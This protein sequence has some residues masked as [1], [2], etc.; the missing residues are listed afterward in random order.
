[1][2]IVET[3]VGKILTMVPQELFCDEHQDLQQVRLSDEFL[4][5]LE[6]MEPRPEALC[7]GR[8]LPRHISSNDESR[9]HCLVLETDRWLFLA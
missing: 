6:R 8:G 2:S 9:L 5:E 1:M 3:A 7:R 4:S